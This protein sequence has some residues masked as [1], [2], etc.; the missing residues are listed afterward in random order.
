MQWRSFLAA[1]FCL[2][3]IASMAAAQGFIVPHDHDHPYQLPRPWPRPNDPEITYHV[4]KLEIDAS[5]RDQIAQTRVV[6]TFVNTCNQTI[7]AIFVFPLPHDGAIDSMT[8]LV[9]GK[10]IAGKMLPADE[11]KR[12]YESYVRQ[13]RDP[14]LLQYLG[15][16]MLQTSVFPIP[17][18]ATRQVVLSY[19]QLL[20]KNEQATDFVFPLATARYTAKPLEKL[21]VR[22]AIESKEELK[23]IYSPSHVVQV[24]RDDARH[25][26]A[27]YEATQSI[28][29][30]D[31][32]L[33]FDAVAGEI[34][35]NLISYWPPGEDQGYFVLLASPR[36]AAANETTIKKTVLFVVDRS[37]SM[38]G[39]KIDQAR[40]A[41]KFVINNLRTEDL[42]N[43]IVYD[44]HV[45]SF[46]PELQ[47]F[48]ADACSAALGFVNGINAGGGTNIDTALQTALQQMHAG[49]DAPY[50]VF[51]TDGLPTVGETNELKI[52]ENSK[53]LNKGGA[54]II[55]FGVGYDVN[56][57]L[58]DRIARAHR[59]QSEYVRPNQN[60]EEA[61]ARLFRKI[62]S[63]VLT[64]VQLDYRFPHVNVVD[65]EPINRVYPGGP[66]DLF[67]GE[68]LAIVG[69]YRKSGPAKIV[70]RGK[71]GDQ[72]KQFDFE[73]SFAAP[74]EFPQ[75][76]FA[77]KLW[78][79]R[80]I[81]EII[82]SIDLNG[83]NQELV[84][85]LT[86]LSQKH[87]I[88]TPYTA[89][90]ADE[91]QG[92]TP[93]AAA[94]AF[95]ATRERLEAL[96]QSGG[97]GGFAQRGAKNA[98]RGAAN[99][100]E[101]DAGV[102]LYLGDAGQQSGN[103]VAQAFVPRGGAPASSS[104]LRNEKGQALFKR[105]QIVF[106]ANAADVDIEKQKSEIV[107]VTRFSDE[108]FELVHANSVAENE[109]LAAQQDDEELVVRLRDRIYRIK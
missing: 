46:R 5:I 65:G 44:D 53:L 38:S 42:F 73:A 15:Q 55:C 78:A 25:A 82:D 21:S 50:L 6:Q 99:L 26:I 98:Y 91:N 36:F 71:V 77:E 58:L 49:A 43:V 59:G 93:L 47:R 70:L 61:V 57:R 32:R 69:R 3:Q 22:V 16:G 2:L 68:Q 109:L 75:N 80:R 27:R 19:S 96:S 34:G 81:G 1:L 79:A 17:P 90:L 64:D 11:A 94:E 24:Q 104:G 23:N 103:T 29:T 12:I 97:Q 101:A 67:R 86:E 14:A 108:Y 20:R 48:N 66:L 74:G 100:A 41:A 76:R 106:A 51:L 40:E 31:F 63:P 107:E 10:E 87:G 85:E 45:E 30:D 28:P 52:V 9:D 62:A 84:Q 102:Q 89:Y 56:S 92:P 8:F 7:Q 54:R 4:Q 37:G 72:E 95:G 39:E 88:L 60:I 105:G 35:A 83:M 18:G 13:F 33:I